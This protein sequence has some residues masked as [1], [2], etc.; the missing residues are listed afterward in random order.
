MGSLTDKYC[1]VS[2]GHTAITT[3]SGRS[4]LSLVCEAV[5]N[6]L[7][8][9]GLRA[10]DID[11][12]TSFRPND[13]AHSAEVLRLSPNLTTEA[14]RRHQFSLA[15]QQNWSGTSTICARRG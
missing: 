7:G 15:I 11:G 2:M 4:T 10:Q 5:K 9:A 1:I 6:A 12:M 3:N 14:W 13:C 8:D